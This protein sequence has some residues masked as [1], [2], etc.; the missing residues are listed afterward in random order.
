MDYIN[1]KAEGI[2]E[3]IQQAMAELGGKY[4][5]VCMNMAIF[6]EYCN[7]KGGFARNL[8]E[9]MED[10]ITFQFKTNTIP[11]HIARIIG[12]S[13]CIPY[14]M[15]FRADKFF[16]QDP[17][18]F[19]KKGDGPAYI[20]QIT[21]RCLAE[22][23]DE[24]TFTEYDA[25]AYPEINVTLAPEGRYAMVN[26]ARLLR[27]HPDPREHTKKI[28]E[29]DARLLQEIIAQLVRDDLLGLQHDAFIEYILKR[30]GPKRGLEAVQEDL[31]TFIN[32]SETIPG[33]MAHQWAEGR[34]EN[35]EYIIRVK[36]KIPPGG[37]E[38]AEETYVDPKKVERLKAAC[39]ELNDIGM[40]EDFIYLES[41][42]VAMRITE[43][44]EPYIA[45]MGR[46]KR[47][48]MGIVEGGEGVGSAI[49]MKEGSNLLLRHICEVCGKEEI[50]SAGEAFKKGW[51]Y[52]PTMGQFGLVSPRTCANCPMEATLW[53]AITW[54]NLDPKEMT[55]SQKAT[56]KRILGEPKSILP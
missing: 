24:K 37:E 12:I 46:M 10:L 41:G 38:G 26:M 50:L 20:R 33:A 56:L 45:E 11:N 5:A 19:T 2:P 34:G 14:R 17:E 35:R 48:I 44:A 36:R 23:K 42:Y 4:P 55:D 49:V 47:K 51:D 22:L 39:G 8:S 1:W 52:P 7:S 18:G 3:E 54:N 27:I 40:L 6:P 30:G 29:E 31:R 53:A 28:S 9:V 25:D 13:G 16:P 15:S 21:E 43:E 32:I